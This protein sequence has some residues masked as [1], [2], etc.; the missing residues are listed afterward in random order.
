[1]SPWVIDRM[2]EAAR[3]KAKSPPGVI[4]Q[5]AQEIRAAGGA[6][7]EFEVLGRNIVWVPDIVRHRF[8]CHS[9]D[10]GNFDVRITP[11]NGLDNRN[12]PSPQ[13]NA[14]LRAWP[15]C[16]VITVSVHTVR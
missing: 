10:P 11:L 16:Q 13:A 14:D 7:R 12:S 15:Y 8:N 1:S 2:M 4:D 9:R 6:H 3:K 5:F